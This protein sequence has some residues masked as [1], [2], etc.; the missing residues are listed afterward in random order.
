MRTTFRA[1]V[2]LALALVACSPDSQITVNNLNS[3]DGT[4]AQS[5]E[6]GAGEFVDL[7]LFLMWRARG[8]KMETPGVR[9]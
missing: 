6:Y 5:Y 1:A 2:G 7:E 3:P 8:M 4:R 9:P